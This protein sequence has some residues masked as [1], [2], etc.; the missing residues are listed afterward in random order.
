MFHKFLLLSS[1]IYDK[2]NKKIENKIFLI[3]QKDG[4]ISF[5]PIYIKKILKI[6]IF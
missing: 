3:Q 1:N 5:F 6:D 2:A 4:Q